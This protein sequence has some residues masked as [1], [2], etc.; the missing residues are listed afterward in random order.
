MKKTAIIISLFV[1]STFLVHSQNEVD[2]LRYSQLSIGG[3]A[4]FMGL[5]G[6]FSA[7]GADLSTMSTNPAG[8][9][10]F[11]SSEFTFTPAYY[12][13]VT[14]SYYYNGFSSDYKGNFNISNAGFVYTMNVAKNPNG[15]GFQNVQLGFAMVRNNNFHKRVL[16][17]GTNPESSLLDAYVEYA[18]GVKPEN[19]DPF[20]TQLA[21]ET[22]LIDP[23]QN[24][25]SYSNRAPLYE[26]GSIAPVNQRKSILSEGYMNEMGFSV[27]AN[28]ADVVY[29]GGTIGIPV[30]RYYEETIYE[31]NNTVSSDTIYFSSFRKYD[32][33]ETRG[34]GFNFKFGLIVRATD[35]MRLGAAFHTPSYFGNLRDDYRST[36]SSSLNNGDRYSWSSPQGGFNYSLETPMRAIGAISFIIKQS[37][38]VSAEYEYVDYSSATLRSHGYDFINENQAI[39]TNYTSASNIKI[40]TEWRFGYFSL[41][42]GYAVYGSPYKGNIND[43]M[44]SIISGGIG[45]R[46]QYFFIDFAYSHSFTKENYYMYE[47]ENVLVD[48]ALIET[49]THNFLLTLGFKY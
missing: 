13:A 6:A 7:V 37:G 20:D 8:L 22:Y 24:T 47:S 32:Y 35:W 39:R 10:L 19:L 11:K 46:Q 42:G 48:P 26:D 36:I 2:A 44:K 49:Y 29:F 30:I 27:A 31:E 9:G 34:S 5:A 12:R 45:Y 40:G 28:Y 21:Y 4:R 1:L 33:L 3:T 25:L 17:V 15:D 41:R 18:E 23:I 43:G 16:I 38:L 14:D